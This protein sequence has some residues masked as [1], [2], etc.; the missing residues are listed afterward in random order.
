MLYSLFSY[1]SDVLGARLFT[2]IS[3]RAIL[4]GIMALCIGIWFGKYFIKWMKEH[5][6]KETLR[7]DDKKADSE[8]ANVPT[9]GGIIVILAILM[10]R[11]VDG[12][13]KQRISN[14]SVVRL[15]SAERIQRT[16]IV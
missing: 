5:N 12:N 11:F 2:Y 1:F 14:F 8:K 6:I 3:F 4:A 15:N 13:R 16:S 9:M 10:R 7:E